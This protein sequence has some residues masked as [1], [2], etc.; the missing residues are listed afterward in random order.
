MPGHAP[1]PDASTRAARSRTPA[2]GPAD[3]PPPAAAPPA[4]S[5][6]PP[7]ARPGPAIAIASAATFVAFLDVT[8]VNIALPD[9]QRDFDDASL[10][11]LSWV[12]SIYGVLFAALLTPAGRLADALGRT[13]V[14]LAGFAAF[15]LTS[16]LC[17]VAPDPAT[18]IAARALQG[19]GAAFMIPAALAIVL[20]VA[21]PEKRAA[22][23]GLWGATTS[24]AAAA[25]PILGSLLIDAFS[26]RAVF[27]IN[28]PIGIAVLLAG[29]RLL[30]SL[31]PA[32]G[33]LPDLPGATVLAAGA[34]LVVVALT[35]TAQWGWLDGRTLACAA[36]G[37]AL[38]AA[39]LRRAAGH[40]AP[41]IEVGLWRHRGFAISNLAA[42]L[43]GFAL[44]AWL[45]VAV[46]FLTDVWRYTI[47]EAGLAV[48]PGAF[49]SAL[50]AVV[51]GRHVDR[52]GPRGAVVAGGLLYAVAGAWFV[53]RL[54]AEHELWQLWVPV[55]LVVGAGMGSVTVGIT[56]AAAGS[57]PPARFAAGT[58]LM[59][60]ARQL[61]GALGVAALAAVLAA[62]DAFD[63]DAYRAVFALSTA[64]AALVALTGLRL[65]R[66]AP[67]PGPAAAAPAAR[68]ADPHAPDPAPEV[69]A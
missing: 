61:G 27:L 4:A 42:A 24:V 56:S 3:R 18:L 69:T 16:A 40:P 68:T 34:A 64:G 45:L 33:R 47:V 32:A 53:A 65:A 9:L 50:G 1:P 57:L 11:A 43:N 36:G 49:T 22:A 30:P 8:V 15:T 38:L 59:M 37:V 58:G 17:A 46:L 21:P 54:G 31:R 67:A 66:P 60:T 44:F 6:P 55:G 12:V 41:A 35:E 52:H 13:R 23:V 39:A 14:F 19:A 25:G 20:A 2:A 63:P 51:A 7:P 28:V 62:S 48:T 10:V 26:W 5:A 29:A